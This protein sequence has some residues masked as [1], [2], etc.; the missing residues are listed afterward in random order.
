MAKVSFL[1]VGAQKAGTTTL[2][3]HLAGHPPLFMSRRKELH[4]FDSDEHD[5]E[6]P[7][8][9]GF[10]AHFADASPGQICGEVTPIYMFRRRFLERIRRYN[11]HI[12]LVAILRNPISRAF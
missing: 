9:T 5:W 6:H 4:F 7:D 2:Y 1:V 10:E 8:Y 12:R 3:S 11:P